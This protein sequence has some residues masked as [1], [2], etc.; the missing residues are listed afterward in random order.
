M[1]NDVTLLLS[2]NFET[3]S[4]NE[5]DYNKVYDGAHR[6]SVDAGAFLKKSITFKVSPA[7]KNVKAEAEAA[8]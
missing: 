3:E 8:A 1:C 5:N 4:L 6:L 2:L 7:F